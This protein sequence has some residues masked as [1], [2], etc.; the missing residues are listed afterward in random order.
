MVALLSG[1]ARRQSIPQS[2]MAPPAGN[3]GAPAQ[4]TVL[5]EAASYPVGLLVG[6]AHQALECFGGYFGGQGLFRFGL[7]G[8]VSHQGFV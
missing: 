7:I 6:L 4:R 3:Q 8:Q 1:L 5:V 2:P